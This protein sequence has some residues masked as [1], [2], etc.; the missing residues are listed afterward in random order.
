MIEK[1]RILSMAAFMARGLAPETGR[2]K[3]PAL[4]GANSE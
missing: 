3:Q 1:L 4:A 2:G